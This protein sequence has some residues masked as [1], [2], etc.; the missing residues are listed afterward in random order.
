MHSYFAILAI[1]LDCIPFPSN[2]KSLAACWPTRNHHVTKQRSSA[3]GCAKSLNIDYAFSLALQ[4]PSR[5]LVRARTKQI[6]QGAVV[7]AVRSL[8][9]C[10]PVQGSMPPKGVKPSVVHRDVV[11]ELKQKRKEGLRIV[12][13]AEK[14]QRA[15]ERAHRKLMKKASALQVH[16][17]AL[18]LGMKA[19]G[20]VDGDD[21]DARS[22]ELSAAEKVAQSILELGRE[23]RNMTTSN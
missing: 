23:K 15:A 4:S 9:E 7:V 22:Q 17:L 11:A 16:E 6:Q 2:S 3:C 8:F 18:I 12:K 20:F 1:V 14:K 13:E 10:L 5:T 19:Q 21:F